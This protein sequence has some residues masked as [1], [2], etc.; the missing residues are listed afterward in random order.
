M[1][2]ISRRHFLQSA[3]AVSLGFG[4]LDR[5][6]AQ[7]RSL[8][9]TGIADGFGPLVADPDGILDLPEGFRY[10]IISRAGDRMADGFRVP[11]APDGMAAFPGPD[12]HTLLVRNHENSADDADEEG[13]FGG[14]ADPFLGVETLQPGACYDPGESRPALGGTTN[15]LVDTRTLTTVEER[16]S[17]AGTIRN[18][19][20]GPTP[21]GTWITCEETT[22]RAG[23][24]GL[25]RDHGYNFEVPASM[26]GLPVQPVALT[27]M[28]RFNH[29]AVAVHPDSGIVYQTEDRGDS[30]IYRFIPNTPGE[31]TAGGRL[32]AL[33]VVDRPSLDT[34]NW[35]RQRVPVGQ[36]YR[37]TWIDLDEID[38]PEDDLRLRG[39]EAGAARFARG[40]G[41]WYGDGAIYF[42]CTNGGQAEKGQ[43]W[44]YT[45]GADEG[46]EAAGGPSG[47]L[48]LFV[49][50]NDGTL[51]ENA[52]NLCMSP[53][54]DLIVCEDG[55][56]EDFLVGVTPEGELYKFARCAGSNSELAGACFSPDG[57]T[58]FVNIQADGL[59]VAI[60]GPW[61]AR[62]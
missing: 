60:Q 26:D 19:A 8:L 52:D 1:P 43:I 34:R 7:P 4:G 10:R 5:L 22:A 28:G 6:F 35:E 32:Q 47:I 24:E 49:E 45:P 42:A 39:W 9:A 48:E 50:P 37:T 58:L 38:A 53:W 44:R 31:L 41:M 16:L 62:G 23:E 25:R 20:G 55:T 29:E 40:E 13:P 18:C 17:L 11:A 12:G 3:A 56:G 27:A 57:T 61:D 15:L 14:E 30:L 21:W 36:R 33:A 2:R 59:T 54:G 46:Q 51:V